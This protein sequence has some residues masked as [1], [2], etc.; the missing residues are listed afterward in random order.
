M[1]SKPAPPRQ[2]DKPRGS[3]TNSCLEGSERQTWTKPGTRGHMDEVQPRIYT[4]DILKSNQNTLAH[5]VTHV[6]NAADGKFKHG[7]L[8]G[9]YKPHGL[10]PFHMASFDLCPFFCSAA[11]FIKTAL[12]S[13]ND[14]LRV[15]CVMGR[16]RSA[17]L[18]LAY[19][20]ICK[21]MTVVDAMDHGSNT[22]SP[23]GASRNSLD[24][25][26]PTS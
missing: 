18:F 25:W 20:M 22:A 3:S 23:T 13:P 26:T 16:S 5:H 1:P 2:P 15:H 10:E 12:S 24:S 8:Q 9:H 19:L 6:L 11:K 14:K 17:T 21:K 7:L 4:G